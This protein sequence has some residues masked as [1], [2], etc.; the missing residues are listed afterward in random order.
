MMKLKNKT[1]LGKKLRRIGCGALGAAVVLGSTLSLS[2]S[3]LTPSYPSMS[4][5]FDQSR[6]YLNLCC[7]TLSG[8]PRTDLVMVA[9]SQLGYH[10]GDCARQTNGENQYGENNYVEYNYYYG[11]VDQYGTGQGTYSYPWCASFVTY[12]ARMAGIDESVLPSSVNCARW[13]NLFRSMGCYHERSDGY[14]PQKGDLIFFR[15]AASSKLSTHVGIV[16]Y[17]YGNT[18][19]TIEGNLHDEVS[20]AAYDCQSSYIIG[21]ASPAYQENRSAGFSYLLD[22][23]SEG[24]YI[25]AAQNLPVY[26]EIGSEWQTFT[27]HRGDLMH[28]Y[29]T[30]GMWGRTDYGWIHLPDTQPVDVR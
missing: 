18:V 15:S 24:N 7:L 11:T 8:D 26:R 4:D 10:E 23:Y 3:A 5:A 17:T 22:V 30:K 16:R 1:Q 27:L 14:V 21:Y 2:V 6:Y 13:V 12:C 20:L 28:V 29:E 19:Y 25:I 9:M